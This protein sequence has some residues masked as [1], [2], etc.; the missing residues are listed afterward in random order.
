VTALLASKVGIPISTT[1]CL[2]GSVVFVGVVKSGDGIKWSIF[3]NIVF[4]WLVTLPVSGLIS[5]GITLILKL[6]VIR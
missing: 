6:T 3:R 1:H 4:S 5:A 2:V